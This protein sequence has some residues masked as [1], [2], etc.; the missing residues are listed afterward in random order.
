MFVFVV[1]VA[2]CMC[3]LCGRRFISSTTR[4]PIFHLS[5]PFFQQPF[6]FF[7]LLL[8]SIPAAPPHEACSRN[9]EQGWQPSPKPE[10]CFGHP[11]T[12][13]PPPHLRAPPPP[14]CPSHFSRSL[15]S[16]STSKWRLEG[17]SDDDVGGRLDKQ[18][19][20]DSFVSYLAPGAGLS[21]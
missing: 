17:L 5:P 2:K 15:G 9:F 6:S 13:P 19:L 7:L 16:R 11:R 4:A 20:N 3:V 18:A 10:A 1:E 21:S 12:P 8:L 14:P